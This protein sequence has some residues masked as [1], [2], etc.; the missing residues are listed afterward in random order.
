MGAPL[1]AVG[2]PGRPKGFPNG[3]T[4]LRLELEAKHGF[5][6]LAEAVKRFRDPATPNASKDYCLGLIVDRIAPKLK[7]VEHSVANSGQTQQVLINI[8]SGNATVDTP[9]NP[10]SQ[11]IVIEQ[12]HTIDPQS[13]VVDAECLIVS[14]GEI[15]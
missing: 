9:I 11:Q 5:D 15:T 1:F 6:W 8:L 10:P 14:N 4:K 13:Q 3:A 12:S 2:N 7:A